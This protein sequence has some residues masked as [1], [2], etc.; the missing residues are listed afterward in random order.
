[1]TRTTII[2][3]FALPLALCFGACDREDTDNAEPNDEA[4]A[5]SEDGERGAPRPSR[6]V[7][8]P[9]IARVAR[10]VCSMH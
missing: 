10:C 1:M 7:K 3:L 2:K 6:S 8:R 5:Q 9:G 4:V